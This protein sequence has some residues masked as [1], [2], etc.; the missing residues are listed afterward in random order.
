MN[1]LPRQNRTTDFRYRIILVV[2]IT[3]DLYFSVTWSGERKKTNKSPCQYHDRDLK[4]KIRIRL[5]FETLCSHR[6]F[7]V[8]NQVGLRQPLILSSNFPLLR[9]CQHSFLQFSRIQWISTHALSHN[10]DRFKQTPSVEVKRHD[11]F[12]T[13]PWDSICSPSHNAANLLFWAH[14]GL[15]RPKYDHRQ[16]DF[17]VVYEQTYIPGAS[18]NQ[19]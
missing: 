17:K 10:G 19:F 5:W 6:F 3:S 13:W 11:I 14:L 9:L 1:A 2:T 15:F 16:Y 7:L 18:F 8:P 12:Y 4:I